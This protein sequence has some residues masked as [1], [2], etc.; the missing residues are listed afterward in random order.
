DLA[1]RG[2]EHVGEEADDRRL[3]RRVGPD[4]PEH[5]AGRHGKAQL[6]ELERRAAPRALRIGEAHAS[7]LRERD[8]GATLATRE[9]RSQMKNGA[10][11]KEVSTPTDSS[12]G[13][14]TVRAR[15]S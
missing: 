10:P 13:A 5:L 2:T 4:E 1:A 15:G 14:T 11:Q 6:A 9:R 12:A 3:P 8:H 7:K